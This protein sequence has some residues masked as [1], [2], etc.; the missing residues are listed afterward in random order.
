MI[1]IMRK[2]HVVTIATAI[3]FQNVNL[4]FRKFRRKN[5]NI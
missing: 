3:I 5:V 4:F 2:A 1:K